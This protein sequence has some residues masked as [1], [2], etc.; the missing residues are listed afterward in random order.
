[1][2]QREHLI[3]HRADFEDRQCRVFRLGDVEVGVLRLGD[4]FYAYANV[5]PHQG[6]PV[7]EGLVL[8]KVEAVVNADRTISGERFSSTRLHIVCPWHGYEYE[9]T[10]GRCAADARLGLRPFEV[11]EREGELYV[12][13]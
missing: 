8:G 1:V 4:R 12:V 5:C 13:A 9:A 6:G 7:C 11:R 10:T 2:G 3:G